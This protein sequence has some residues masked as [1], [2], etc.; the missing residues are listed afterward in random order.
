VNVHFSQNSLFWHNSAQLKTL[1]CH[2]S[3]TQHPQDRLAYFK[4][5]NM[6]TILKKNDAWNFENFCQG[7]YAKK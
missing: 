5:K 2:S 3:Q 6:F 4:L 7:P 1:T